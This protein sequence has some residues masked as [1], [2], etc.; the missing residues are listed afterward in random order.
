M[1]QHQAVQMKL[2]A[3]AFTAKPSSGGVEER[4]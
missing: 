4:I 1:P 3:H 2:T